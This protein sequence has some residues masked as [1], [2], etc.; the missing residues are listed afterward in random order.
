M[1]PLHGGDGGAS[2]PDQPLHSWHHEQQNLPAQQVSSALCA[3][4]WSPLAAAPA[5]Q[6]P[7]AVCAGQGRQHCQ[8]LRLAPQVWA[9]PLVRKRQR[10]GAAQHAPGSTCMQD[11]CLQAQPDAQGEAAQHMHKTQESCTGTALQL[12]GRPTCGEAAGLRRCQRPTLHWLCCRPWL[13]SGLRLTV[14]FSSTRCRQLCTASAESGAQLDRHCLLRLQSPQ[15]DLCSSCSCTAS[16][17]LHQQH[18]LSKQSTMCSPCADT[19]QAD[20]V[21]VGQCAV[22]CT[23][24]AQLAEQSS[25]SDG[26]PCAQAHCSMRCNSSCSRSCCSVSVGS[27]YCT[28]NV[29]LSSCC[30]HFPTSMAAQAETAG[31]AACSGCL[32]MPTKAGGAHSHV[33]NDVGVIAGDCT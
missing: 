18:S 12:S 26:T 24:S 21:T 19:Y 29:T 13:P 6:R 30:G 20:H 1:C 31:Q 3:G 9:W 27:S 8:A 11:L 5:G 22:S 4:A 32:P 14:Q 2:V 23:L 33:H 28:P 16:L 25:N 7:A 17:A 10:S 15:D